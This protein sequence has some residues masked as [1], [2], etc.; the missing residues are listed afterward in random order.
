MATNYVLSAAGTT[1]PILTL[2]VPTITGPLAIPTLQ[3]VT[4]SNSNDVFTWTQLNEASKMQVPT[5]ANNSISTNIVV[6]EKTFFG[7]AVA[8]AGSAAKLGLYGLSSAKTKCNFT[9]TMG[10]KTLSGSGYV[11]GLAPTV[12]ADSPVWVTPLTITVSGDYT[13]A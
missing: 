9:I 11:S 12:S 10:S 8:T 6:E 1:N 7:D 5:T 3:D 4:I 13:V 2:T